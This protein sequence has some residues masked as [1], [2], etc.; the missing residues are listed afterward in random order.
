MP[1]QTITENSIDERAVCLS[2]QIADSLALI[3]GINIVQV[4]DPIKF[5][6]GQG[7]ISLFYN[8]GLG[9]SK[10]DPVYDPNGNHIDGTLVVLTHPT[11][12]PSLINNPDVCMHGHESGADPYVVETYGDASGGYRHYYDGITVVLNEIDNPP[13]AEGAVAHV[14]GQ[15]FVSRKKMLGGFKWEELPRQA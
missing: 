12:D 13:L 4:C 10:Q 7:W 3:P 1:F 14:D 15:T 2:D 5:K 11:I 9:Y 6:N 8:D